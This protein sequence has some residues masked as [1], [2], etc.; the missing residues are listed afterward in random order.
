MSKKWTNKIAHL[1]QDITIDRVEEHSDSVELFISFPEH[2]RICPECG[3]HDCVRHD[4]GK[5]ETV[6]HIVRVVL[7][8]LLILLNFL[9]IHQLF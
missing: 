8:N 1:P 6:R 7:K 2:E 5:Y 3:S 9:L 4:S